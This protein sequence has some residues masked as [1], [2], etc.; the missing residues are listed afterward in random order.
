MKFGPARKDSPKAP[1]SA[2]PSAFTLIEL[3]VVIA[4][5]AILAS[6]LLPA[7]AQAKTS[8]QGIKCLSNMRQL[9][10]AAIM[11]GSDNNDSIPLNEGHAR[12]GPF[13]GAAPYD[14]NWVGGSFGSDGGTAS[15][16]GAE[17]NIWLLGT[18]GP[19]DPTGD[20]KSQLGGSIGLYA[21][22]AGV[23]KC[24]SDQSVYK[25]GK[26]SLPRVRSCSVNCYMG[27]T[28]YEQTLGEV[29]SKYFIFKRFSVF[30]SKLG[31][32]DAFSFTDENPTSLNDGFLLIE[33]PGGGGD[34]PAVNHGNASSLTFADGHAQLHKWRD[35]LLVPRKGSGMTDT[36][37]LGQ[38]VSAYVGP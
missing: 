9:Q 20:S 35:A 27:T 3:L 8:A 33:E 12:F 28:P 26:L 21:K 31:P 16:L 14:Y 5:I 37:W 13:I 22:N 24:P 30:P 32:A 36:R 19:I 15:P 25:T 7:L 4:I 2:R 23:Y 29:A 6:L 38:H 11:Y 18:L 34:A 1:D 17:T 10:L